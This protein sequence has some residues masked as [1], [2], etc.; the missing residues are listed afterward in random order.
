MA[1]QTASNDK[2]I[3]EAIQ[4]LREA[5]LLNPTLDLPQRGYSLTDAAGALGVTYRTALSYIKEGRLKAHKVGGKWNI[6]KADLEA[7][8]KQ[9]K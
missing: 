4:T 6:D 1:K 5:G 2:K 7:F 9:G 3:L 8:I